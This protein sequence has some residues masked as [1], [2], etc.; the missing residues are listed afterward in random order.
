MQRYGS[1]L[2]FFCQTCPYVYQLKETVSGTMPANHTP[3]FKPACCVCQVYSE[4]RLDNKDIDEVLGGPDAWK[5][6]EQTDGERL[7]TPPASPAPPRA[8]HPHQR[9][10]IERSL[11][12]PARSDLQQV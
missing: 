7:R 2:R 6:A 12:L 8:R 5:D 9:A 4:V 3:D 10:R 1:Q 11:L